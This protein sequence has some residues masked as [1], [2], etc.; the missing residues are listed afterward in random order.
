[1]ISVS[2]LDVVPGNLITITGKNFYPDKGSSYLIIAGSYVSINSMTKTEIKAV[3]P[4]IASNYIPSDPGALD[5]QLIT[6]TTAEPYHLTG[7]LK[8][9]IVTSV[10]PT[11][12][13][14]PS[15]FVTITGD[16]FIPAPNQT[17]NE[18]SIGGY[19]AAVYSSTKTQIVVTIDF[20]PSVSL[21]LQSNLNVK[22]LNQSTSGPL[23]TI[24]FHGLWTQ[25][26]TPSI[27]P[28]LNVSFGLG[29]KGYAGLGYNNG[30]LKH[31]WEYDPATDSW[32]ALPDF[33]GES[34]FNPVYFTALGKAYIG[35][36]YNLDY[37]GG[38]KYYN[39]F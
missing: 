11:T 39:D 12:I 20:D 13:T 10:T 26:S 35:L 2:P 19:K 8:A 22:V 36:G 30:L 29:S 9:P 25:H 37:P 7:H 31:F 23:T 4:E 15:Q 18:V 27:D 34:R 6:C 16:N 24:D 32:I 38:Q 28:R 21:Y 14:S 33:P 3:I 17:N 5:I 1:M